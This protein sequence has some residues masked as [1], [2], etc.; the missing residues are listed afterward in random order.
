MATSFVFL[1]PTDYRFRALERLPSG[2]CCLRTWSN[3]RFYLRFP[4]VGAPAEAT[5]QT[6]FP[7]V[8]HLPQL[9]CLALV[10]IYIALHL[11]Q[12]L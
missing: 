10:G 11:E 4:S 2:R 9:L 12:D 3:K 1:I 7:R 6:D 5:D 8:K